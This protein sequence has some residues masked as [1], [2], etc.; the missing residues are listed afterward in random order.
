MDRT[1]QNLTTRVCE[2]LQWQ[3]DCEVLAINVSVSFTYNKYACLCDSKI[4]ATLSSHK[5]ISSSISVSFSYSVNVVSTIQVSIMK[6]H[7]IHRPTLETSAFLCI[8]SMIFYLFLYLSK[9]TD[10][11]HSAARDPLPTNNTSGEEHHAGN[12]K[13]K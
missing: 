11:K 3:L 4:I 5:D 13:G 6:V 10:L 2:N 7:T 8:L 12:G 1:P 9:V